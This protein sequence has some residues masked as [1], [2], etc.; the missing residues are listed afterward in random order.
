M[1]KKELIQIR[2]TK[3]QKE[4]IK[5]IST[6]KEMTISEFLLYSV[7]RTITEEEITKLYYRRN[8]LV[9]NEEVK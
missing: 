9:D 7:M 3:E 8:D 6:E 5:R 4:Q 2:V 1:A